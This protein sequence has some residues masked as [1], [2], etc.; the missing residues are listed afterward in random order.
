MTFDQ[1][2]TPNSQF[3]MPP[4]IR[5][6]ETPHFYK[7]G[8]FVFQELCRDLFDVESDISTCEIYG[9]RGQSQDDID[10]LVFQKDIK[11]INE[12]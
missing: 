6:G 4:G 9:K 2:N 3:N 5:P 10:L 12:G 1:F 7:L 8:E 11:G